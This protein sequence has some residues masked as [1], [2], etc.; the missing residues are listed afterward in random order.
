MVKRNILLK[1]EYHIEKKTG[2]KIRLFN[3]FFVEKNKMIYKIIYKN[4][5][6]EI[7]EFLEDIHSNYPNEDSVTIKL[8]ILNTN[9]I[10]AEQMFEGCN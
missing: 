10:N 7:K 3:A 1:L 9:I 5:I 4:K 8:M 2:K 6:Y